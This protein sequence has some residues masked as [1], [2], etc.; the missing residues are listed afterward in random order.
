MLKTKI[1]QQHCNKTISQIL[2]ASWYLVLPLEEI[3]LSSWRGW[4]GCQPRCPPPP[5]ATC[6]LAPCEGRPPT[7]GTAPSATCGRC[8]CDGSCHWMFCLLFGR[9]GALLLSLWQSSL[10]GHDKWHSN[11]A[12][13]LSASLQ[14]PQSL[15]V[16]NCLALLL[17]T[18]STPGRCRFQSSGFC[19]LLL[20]FVS[21]L[22]ASSCSHLASF[23]IDLLALCQPHALLPF[24]PIPQVRFGSIF[25]LNFSL[26]PESLSRAANSDSMAAFFWP[27][28]LQFGVSKDAQT[29]LSQACSF[30]RHCQGRVFWHQKPIC[31]GF[32]LKNSYFWPKR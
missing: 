6:P 8:C 1:V 16:C 10:F 9:F 23:W 27:W 14:P 19:K 22:S 17:C 13:A 31:H 25:F 5:S 15:V 32:A 24:N 29:I 20:L 18:Q 3:L 2:S 12:L 11:F 7:S 30:L 26:Y 21:W 4:S 28:H